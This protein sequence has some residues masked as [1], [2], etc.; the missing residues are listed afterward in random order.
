MTQPARTEP[1]DP[2]ARGFAALVERT[3]ARLVALALTLGVGDR[4]AAEDVVQ[5]A[6]ARVWRR[7]QA[8]GDPAGLDGYVAQAVRNV[9]LNRRARREVEARALAQQAAPTD[10]APLG[11]TTDAERVAQALAQL[12]DSQREVVV[13]RVYEGLEFKAIAAR[14]GAPLGTIHSR[15][16]LALERLRPHLERDHD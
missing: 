10:A 12:P 3:G 2:L 15:Y 7:R 14:L 8:L 1:D 4:S 16:R 5:E 6:L 9:A 13:L 11:D